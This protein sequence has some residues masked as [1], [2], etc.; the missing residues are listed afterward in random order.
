MT[1]AYMQK[2]L[3]MFPAYIQ[4]HSRLI[5]SLEVVVVFVFNV[6]PTAKVIWRRGPRLKVSS[7]RLVKQGMEPA[8][9]GLQSKRFIHYITAAPIVLEAHTMNPRSS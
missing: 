1:F 9:P 5:L 3:I 8:T 7:D 2:L 6:P 4:K